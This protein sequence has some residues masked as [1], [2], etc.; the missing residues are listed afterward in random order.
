MGPNW[1]FDISCGNINYNGCDASS[2]WRIKNSVWISRLFSDPAFVEKVK[3]R[4][5]EVSSSLSVLINS[6]GSTGGIQALADEISVSAEYNFL[7]WKILGIYV[8][9]NAAGY[10]ER[11]TYQSEVDYMVNWLNCRYNYMD[12]EINA[13]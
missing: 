12:E 13:L 8:W 9:P 6:S 1:D 10:E 5:N 3:A 7:K 11:I 4:W 2:G